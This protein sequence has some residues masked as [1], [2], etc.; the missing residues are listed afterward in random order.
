[1]QLRNSAAG[2]KS[3]Q[4]AAHRGRKKVRKNFPK[5]LTKQIEIVHTNS[6]RRA[7]EPATEAGRRKASRKKELKNCAKGIDKSGDADVYYPLSVTP[8]SNFDLRAVG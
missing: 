6:C 5:P 4:R 7:K 2:P 1:M 8:K 3:Q